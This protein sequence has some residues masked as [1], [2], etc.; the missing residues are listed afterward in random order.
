MMRV[1]LAADHAGFD[2]KAAVATSLRAA[3]YE[4]VDRSAMDAIKTQSSRPRRRARAGVVAGRIL[5]PPCDGKILPSTVSP[6]LP[7]IG[8]RGSG[9]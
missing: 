8:R 2:L 4:V 6:E 3:G 9:V 7:A 1:G 5:P